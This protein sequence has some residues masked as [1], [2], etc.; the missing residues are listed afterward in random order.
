[1]TRSMDEAVASAWQ[2]YEQQL[3]VRIAGL[4]GD[5]ILGLPEADSWGDAF[6]ALMRQPD[7]VVEAQLVV[8]EELSDEDR[9]IA[10]LLGWRFSEGSGAGTVCV[11]NGGPDDLAALVCSTLR[12]L[13]SLVDPAFVVE[14]TIDAPDCDHGAEIPLVIEA[15]ISSESQL[16]ELVKAA[17]GRHLG[18]PVEADADGD[19]A[20]RHGSALAW[21]RVD[22][23]RPAILFHGCVVDRIR[24]RSQ[25]AIE[26]NLLNRDTKGAAF[27]LRD[28][29]VVA[30][31]E[32]L[33]GDFSERV[34]RDTLDTFVRTLDAVDQDLALRV[35]GRTYGQS[36]S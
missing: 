15:G 21:V 14:D 29:A 8:A 20:V 35:G 4:E 9:E 7:G 5:L 11:G 22:S 17:L 1:M 33:A 30:R 25:A 16:T 3:E 34:F 32:L 13:F 18:R 12:T 28:R 19:F 23:E 10:E 27:V 26:V 31:H 6:V 24:R 2:N 36:A